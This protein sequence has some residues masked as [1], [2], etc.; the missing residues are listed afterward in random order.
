MAGRFRLCLIANGREISLN[1]FAT[2]TACRRYAESFGTTV[3]EGRIY[4][5]DKLV[6]LHRRS[7]EG[8]GTRWYKA[9]P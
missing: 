1:T 5:G 6:G 3:D 2:I 7:P 9:T 4:L 8:D